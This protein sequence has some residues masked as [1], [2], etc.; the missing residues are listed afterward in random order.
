MI[1]QFSLGIAEELLKWE[2]ARCGLSNIFSLKLFL[3]PGQD[4][5]MIQLNHQ[6]KLP[7]LKESFTDVVAQIEEEIIDSALFEEHRAAAEQELFKSQELLTEMKAEIERLK[8][9]ETW[10]LMEA[11]LINMAAGGTECTRYIASQQNRNGDQ[12]D[13]STSQ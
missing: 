12:D 7:G 13:P 5:A 1:N 9:Y 4:A 10:Y 6:M 11:E 2:L 3:S 8:K